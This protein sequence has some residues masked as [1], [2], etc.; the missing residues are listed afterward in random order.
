[1]IL[2]HLKSS[3]RHDSSRP[4]QNE[5]VYGKRRRLPRDFTDVCKHA[6]STCDCGDEERLS[7][8]AANQ[9][10][11][12][13]QGRGSRVALWKIVSRIRWDERALRGR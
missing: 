2:R 1:M 10:P 11:G 3:R 9:R 13:C 5:V 12:E 7:V 8:R 4:R 6:S